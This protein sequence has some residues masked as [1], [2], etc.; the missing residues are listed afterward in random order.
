MPLATSGEYHWQLAGFSTEKSYVIEHRKCGGPA[1]QGL[2]GYPIV[3]CSTTEI[4]C[5]APLRFID[6]TV[7]A[8]T[9]PVHDVC[10]CDFHMSDS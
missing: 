4:T 5:P 8:H 7:L 2:D 10:S 3:R 1:V 6:R 9:G